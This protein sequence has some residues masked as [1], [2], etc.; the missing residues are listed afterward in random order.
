M[1]N[2]TP[3][4]YSAPNQVISYSYVVT[5]TGSLTLDN[6]IVADDNDDPPGVACPVTTLAPSAST[7]C[8]SQRTTT[9][10]DLNL[11]QARLRIPPP[12]AVATLSRSPVSSPADSETVTAVATPGLS[13]VKNATPGTYSAPN[14]VISYSYVVTNTGNLTLDNLVVA[15]DNDDPPGVACTVTTL[16][17][18]DSTTCTA[19]RTVL[20]ADLDGGSIINVATASGTDPG[21]SPVTSPSDSKT[22]TAVVNPA[23]SLVKS[24]AAPTYV[25]IG[26]AIGYSYLVTNEGNVTLTNVT[27]DDD[28]DDDPPGVVCPATL[29]A[30]GEAMTCTSHRTV[31]PSDRGSITNRATASSTT[32][33]GIVITSGTESVTVTAAIPPIPTLDP[34][35]IAALIFSLAGLSLIFLRRRG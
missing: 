15:D 14:Q 1:K 12:P 3:G 28:N 5:N 34:M 4:T 2:A 21:G 9:Q 33:G 13:L 32:L 26:E 6:L 11:M 31:T 23:L 20:Q 30:P 19:Q 35:G 27:V 16:A 22:V 24:S 17:P 7:T 25:A 8:T 29:L 18:G 10:A